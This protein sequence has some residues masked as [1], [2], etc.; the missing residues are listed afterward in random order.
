MVPLGIVSPGS[1]N[2]SVASRAVSEIIVVS[3]ERGG[4]K[5]RKRVREATNALEYPGQGGS[6]GVVAAQQECAHRVADLAI[7]HQVILVVVCA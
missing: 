4:F 6:G 1:S 3:V 2:G 7:A 5:A